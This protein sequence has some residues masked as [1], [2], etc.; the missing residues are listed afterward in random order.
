M[1]F[2]KLKINVR[3]NSSLWETNANKKYIELD[4]KQSEL[5]CSILQ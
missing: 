2:F 5:I 3:F 4:Q 1:K